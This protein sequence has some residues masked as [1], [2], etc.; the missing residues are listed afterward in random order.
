MKKY[1]IRNSYH[2]N[3]SIQSKPNQHQKFMISQAKNIKAGRRTHSLLE[4]IN[5][6]MFS[7]TPN[8]DRTITKKFGASRNHITTPEKKSKT[9]FRVQN[10]KLI[11]EDTRK[12]KNT[13]NR[14]LIKN[15]TF[16]S[17]SSKDLGENHSRRI[18]PHRS[19]TVLGDPR[20]NLHQ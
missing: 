15:S 3:A 9:L 6:I 4:T 11:R 14:N 13:R 2:L 16:Y 5:S 7:L 1:K 18:L 12:Q 17:S 19:R 20:S 10:R 8:R